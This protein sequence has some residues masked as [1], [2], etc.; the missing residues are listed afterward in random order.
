MGR[1]GWTDDHGVSHKM[2]SWAVHVEAARRLQIDLNPFDNPA[3]SPAPAVGVATPAFAPAATPPPVAGLSVGSVAPGSSRLA[4]GANGANSQEDFAAHLATLNQNCTGHTLKYAAQYG[5]MEKQD[6]SDSPALQAAA[7][8]ASTPSAGSVQTGETPQ[9]MMTEALLGSGMGGMGSLM[10]MG[11][12]NS[13]GSSGSYDHTPYGNVPAAQSVSQTPASGSSDVMTPMETVHEMFGSGTASTPSSTVYT[14]V[15]TFGSSSNATLKDLLPD[16]LCSGGLCEGESPGCQQQAV[17]PIEIKQIVFKLSRAFS[18]KDIF[19]QAN[20]GQAM[21]YGLALLP[22]AVQVGQEGVTAAVE[23]PT[24]APGQASSSDPFSEAIDDAF[25][26]RLKRENAPLEGF[27]ESDTLVTTIVKPMHYRFD[28][29]LIKRIIQNGG[30]SLL[31][32]GREKTHGPVRIESFYLRDH[33]GM[34]PTQ[35]RLT[36]MAI[37]GVSAMAV[38]A[39]GYLV[40]QATTKTIRYEAAPLNDLQDCPPA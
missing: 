40:F 28:E 34:H 7:A 22:Q 36:S 3:P 18:I 1:M 2:M 31:S 39:V 17:N 6:V 30:F 29:H 37:G 5:V 19:G 23:S 21:A 11:M 33:P 16:S 20:A 27:G 38:F 35:S 24:P 12:G 13:Y 8:F 14:P 10:G 4:Y 26:R 25:S 9:Q 32:D 15:T